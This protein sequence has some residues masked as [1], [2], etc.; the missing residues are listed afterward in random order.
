[1]A[2]LV[3]KDLVENAELDR[4]AMRTIT[5][6]GVGPRVGVPRHHSGYFQNPLAFDV[7]RLFPGS[8]VATPDR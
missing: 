7:V 4:K 8:N 3:V 1:M 2:T 6:G 5:G